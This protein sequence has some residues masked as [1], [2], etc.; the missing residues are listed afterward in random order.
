MSSIVRETIMKIITIE[1]PL[2]KA[3][4]ITNDNITCD[5]DN[6]AFQ[7]INFLVPEKSEFGL[8]V[9]FRPLIAIE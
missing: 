3:V 4:Q 8:E 5:N 6:L 2:S 7:P 9:I 1:N